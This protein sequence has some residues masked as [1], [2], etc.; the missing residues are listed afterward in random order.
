MG[1][2][3]SVGAPGIGAGNGAQDTPNGQ[4][5]APCILNINAENYNTTYT[6]FKSRFNLTWH[7]DDNNLLYIL[8]SEG[9]RPGGFNRSD[10]K[11][12]LKDASGNAQFHYP[13]SYAPD[14]LTNYEIGYKATLFDHRLQLNLSGYYMNWDNVQFALFDPPFS[15]NTTFVTNGPSYRVLGLEAQAVAKIT[16]GLTV[17]GSMSYNHDTQTVSP[18]LVDNITGSPGFGQCVTTA[19][20]HGNPTPV[21][22]ENPFGFV[23]SVPPFSPDFQG[24]IRAR[25]DW[26][27]ASFNA[28][29]QVGATYVSGEYNEPASYGSGVGVLVPTTVNLRYYQPGYATLDASV[30]IAKGPWHAELFGTNLTDLGTPA[31]SPPP[32]SSSSIGKCRCVPLWSACTGRLQVLDK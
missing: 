7:I 12:V 2:Q 24:N 15:I 28:F 9:F 23:G 29:V 31:P 18:C 16:D 32:G 10:S 19:L 6:G 30:G 26:E 27:I 13:G 22:F 21:P 1:S 20:E 4:C 8:Y 25:Y 14:S 11:K 3:Y 17:Q 5:G